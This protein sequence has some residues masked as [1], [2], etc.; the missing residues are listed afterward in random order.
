MPLCN[1]CFDPDCARTANP[2]AACTCVDIP[3]VVR[4]PPTGVRYGNVISSLPSGLSSITS[5]LIDG[6]R[7]YQAA[8]LQL[9]P[10]VADATA[11]YNGGAATGAG[12]AWYTAIDGTDGAQLGHLVEI[13]KHHPTE[14][15]A[16]TSHLES[17]S[18]RAANAGQRE[19]AARAKGYCESHIDKV[20]S[21]VKEVPKTSDE[22]EDRK[23]PKARL[24]LLCTKGSMTS[25]LTLAQSGSTSGKFDMTLGTNVMN[26]EKIKQV[27]DADTLHTIIRD[28]QSSI[29]LI[30]R[31][32]GRKVWAPYWETIFELLTASQDP[33]YVH[34]LIYESLV[35]MDEL[36]VDPL[37][38]MERRWTTFFIT[39]DKK[40][41]ENGKAS[42]DYPGGSPKD[43][44][45][46]DLTPKLPGTGREHVKF[47]PITKQ[48]EWTGEM[49]T[50][51]GAIA[52]CNKWN[53]GKPCNRGV[54][55]GVNKGKCAYTHK[56]RYCMSTAHTMDQK[57]PAGHANAGSYVCPKH[58]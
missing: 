16:I 8:T 34:E 29:L 57:H 53:E 56:C 42:P 25:K 19:L 11:L 21:A 43:T 31:N 24:Y 47:G 41:G 1:N 39:F 49:R 14:R 55:A 46:G 32:G 37:T 40:F 2:V 3:T 4:D 50:R 18:L 7:S 28:F 5:S 15:E 22:F 20:K 48:G 6:L 58:P 26:F 52:F 17:L 33:R 12:A 36:R 9:T 45:D 30:G 13:F 54:F 44:E 35:K 27:H 10:L 23:A 38:F 51:N